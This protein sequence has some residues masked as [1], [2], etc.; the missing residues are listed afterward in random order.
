VVAHLEQGGES[1]GMWG[2]YGK[3]T[4][5]RRCPHDLVVC[6]VRLVG[7]GGAQI[8]MWCRTRG[9]PPEPVAG[10]LLIQ[11]LRHTPTMGLWAAELRSRSKLQGP[12]RL[13]LHGLMPV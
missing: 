2:M 8:G 13:R 4:S 3:R 6:V 9:T 11:G 12:N 10:G 7:A 1:M 5:R